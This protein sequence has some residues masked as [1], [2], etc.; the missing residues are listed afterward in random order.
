M[1]S[2]FH[3]HS[4][5]CDGKGTLEEH[6]EE[7]KRQQLCS[8]GFSSHAPLPFD[9]A[10]CMQAPALEAYLGHIDTLARTSGQLEIYKGLEVDYIPGEISPADFA[11]QLDYTIG[12]I[13]FV[14][15]DE[16]GTRWEIDGPHAP[17]L[18]GL[19]HIYQGDIRAALDRYF[20]L[21]REM[22]V[23]ASPTI[24]GHL[25]K[26]KIQN[27]HTVLFDENAMW[28]QD[29]ID[30]TLT[31]ITQHGCFIEVNTRGLYQ[32]KSSTP[33]PSPWILKRIFDKKI[34]ITLSSDSH[35]PADVINQFDHTA[36]LLNDI[37][38]THLQVLRDGRWQAIPFTPHGLTR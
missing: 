13:H 37:G 15:R 14:E 5:Y 22:V 30:Q 9:C 1:W 27:Q 3:H 23:H 34:P 35:T 4:N 12:S 19:H 25:D 38:F 11:P 21:T 28:Y 24:V 29:M 2:N 10:W 36:A 31:C 33:Y 8:L 16:T 7:A 18:H 32:K 17:F 6:I 20:E 26:I